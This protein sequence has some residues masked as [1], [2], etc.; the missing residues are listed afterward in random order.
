MLTGSADER[1]LLCATAVFESLERLPTLRKLSLHF[2]KT[3]ITDAALKV[4]GASITR[5]SSLKEL[6]RCV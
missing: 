2:R 5:F 1:E 3:W 4:L 6:S